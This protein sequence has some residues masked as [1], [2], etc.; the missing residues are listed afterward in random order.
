MTTL[1]AG[2]KNL[3]GTIPGLQKPEMHYTYPDKATFSGML[4]DL[5]ET[6][7]PTLTVLDGIEA[8]EGDG[9]TSCLLYTSRCV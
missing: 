7:A 9:P 4:V 8:M 1:S 5:A 3:F 2:I 6:V